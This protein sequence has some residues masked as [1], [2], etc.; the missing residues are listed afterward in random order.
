MEHHDEFL[1]PN[2]DGFDL[3]GVPGGNA[4]DLNVAP[5]NFHGNDFFGDE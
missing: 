1:F 5:L 3:N 4:F 2:N